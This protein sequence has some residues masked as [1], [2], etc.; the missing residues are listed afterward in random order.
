MLNRAAAVSLLILALSPFTEPF[1][2]WH[3]ANANETQ[4]APLESL[5]IVR[6]DARDLSV[7]PV[8]GTGS[9]ADHGDV[10]FVTS[11]QSLHLAGF[12]L[13]VATPTGSWGD[14]RISSTILRL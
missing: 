1:S 4:I 12:F 14:Y 11:V 5:S 3:A 9:F 6:D 13:P 2:A 7:T 10:A 8:D